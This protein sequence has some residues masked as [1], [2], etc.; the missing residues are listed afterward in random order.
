MTRSD[1]KQITKQHFNEIAKAYGVYYNKR[2][3]KSYFFKERIKIIYAL[4]DQ[5]SGIK[6]LD[7]GCGPGK[8]VDFCISKNFDFYGVDISE[9]MI[10][11][12]QQ[13]FDHIDS[14]HFSVGMM[15]KLDFPDHSFDVVLCMGALEYLEE[16]EVLIATSEM[17]RVLKQNGLLI[18]SLLNKQSL[19]WN[20]KFSEKYLE[21][22]INVLRSVKKI[23]K[24]Y[25]KQARKQQ[26]AKYETP[27]CRLFEEKNFRLTLNYC[28]LK[29][30][31]TSYFALNILSPYLDVMFPRFSLFLNRNLS[32][33]F[34]IKLKWLYMAF[35]T[36][37][38]KR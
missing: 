2:S 11:E 14:T 28:D 15:E 24:N 26:A 20:N 35:I 7:V 5:Y 36:V 8:M 18:V 22:L 37:A 9:G 16:S 33:V 6:V 29:I 30:I 3:P 34:K 23:I 17:S 1:Q 19:Y 12:C 4:L 38:R 21:P 32:R 31:N 10:R 27:K 25:L 13:K